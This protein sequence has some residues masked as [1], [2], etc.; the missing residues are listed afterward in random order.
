VAGAVVNVSR[1]AIAVL[2]V[3]GAIVNSAFADPIEPRDN[4][5]FAA[6][7][8]L[9][10]VYRRTAK[11]NSGLTEGPAVAPDGSIY[12]SDMPFGPEDQTII[13]RYDPK[14]R[15]VSV[16]TATAGKSLGLAFDAQGRL[17]A[18]DGADGG[19]RC[20]ARWD[21]KT[22]A[23]TIVADR[24]L[25]KRL[26]A[27]ND[28]CIDRRGRIYFTDPRYAG[29]ETRDLA[30]RAV[31]R[32]ETDGEVVEVTHDVEMPNGIALSPDGRTLYVGDHNNGGNRLSPN[33]PEPKRGVMR[34]YAYPLDEAGDVGGWRRTLVD[35]GE[36]NG[37]DGIAID[38]VGNLYVTC[39]SLKQPGILTIDAEGKTLAFLPT[40]PANQ[41]GVF[42][43]WK[44]IPSHAVFGV[45]DDR[46]SLYVTIDQELHRITCKRT[47]APTAWER[48][49][50]RP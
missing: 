20:I 10:L 22:G 9:E 24:Y 48:A 33:D 31:Y 30:H 42:A 19:G 4:P 16:F 49:K 44:G 41:K 15:K 11:L 1:F 43:D 27:P 12:F 37:C 17:I 2:M 13:H 21:I 36:E 38:D 23:R 29:D 46:H 7:A 35:F 14:T 32:I 45:G 3:A 6:D 18:C 47:G 39:R 40:G 26:N 50:A 28:L 25:G 5:I 34:L 8:K